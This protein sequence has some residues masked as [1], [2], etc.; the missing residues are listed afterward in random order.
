MYNSYAT[1]CGWNNTMFENR[2]RDY[3]RTSDSFC[4]HSTQNQYN[5][6]IN[7]D[8][9]NWET[10]VK[11]AGYI[12]IKSSVLSTTPITTNDNTNEI[13]DDTESEKDDFSSVF[14]GLAFLSF[15][16]VLLCCH[17]L[18]KESEN[19]DEAKKYGLE[20]LEQHYM[21]KRESSLFNDE[22]Y[23]RIEQMNSLD[24]PIIKCIHSTTVKDFV[25]YLLED[26]DASSGSSDM[27]A[28][29]ACTSDEESFEANKSN[30]KD[31]DVQSNISGKNTHTTTN[32]RTSAEPVHV[33]LAINTNS[34]S[35]ITSQTSE[36]T[37]E[38]LLPQSE[39][40]NKIENP[41][42]L[43]SIDNAITIVNTET[44]PNNTTEKRNAYPIAYSKRL[45][46]PRHV[47]KPKK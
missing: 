18:K 11:F 39:N 44:T 24:T 28:Q 19:S 20:G 43:A 5:F 7:C 29:G 42:R 6:L 22:Q 40:N 38:L 31:D 26:N 10:Q 47:P 9:L 1:T 34:Q 3:F 46:R 32:S 13:T 16:F 4:I 21:M 17:H 8:Y 35:R 37:R 23:H 45:N 36:S 30:Y 41:S 2:D 12:C 14:I 15:C 33:S 27:Y 25:D